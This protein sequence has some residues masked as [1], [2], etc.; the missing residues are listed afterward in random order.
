MIE[1]LRTLAGV[2]TV[3]ATTQTPLSP[4]DNW[5]RFAIEGRPEPPQGQQQQAATRAVSNDYFRTMRI[6]LRQGRFFSNTD[7]RVA[8]PLIRW[9]EQQ[10]YPE[11][12]NESQAIPAVIINETMAELYWPNEDPLGKRMR[13]IFSPWLTVVGVVG[14]VRHTGLEYP[15]KSGGLLVTTAGTAIL[16]GGDGADIG[17]SAATWVR[18][19]ANRSKQSTRI[20]L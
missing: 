18:R 11:H 5:T 10:P 4:G 19:S 14:D 8:L 6:P 3:G 9:F 13:I 12:F 2:E 17:G 20:S 7:A 1:R 15:A 16:D